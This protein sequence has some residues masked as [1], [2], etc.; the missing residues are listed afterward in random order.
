MIRHLSLIALLLAATPRWPSRAG[1]WSVPIPTRAAALQSAPAAAGAAARLLAAQRAG[2]LFRRH[3]QDL[4][5]P[6]GLYSARAC[7]TENK[8]KLSPRCVVDLAKL[9]PSSVPPCSRSPLVRQPVGADPR[10]AQARVVGYGKRFLFLSLQPAGGG[11]A[12]GVGIDSQR[13]FL[14]AAARGAGSAAALPVR[15]RCEIAAHSSQRR[16]RPVGERSHHQGGPARDNIW[17]GDA[18]GGIVLKLSPQGKLLMTLGV[19]GKRGEWDEAKGQRLLW[20]AAGCG[21]RRQWRRLHR[22]GSRQ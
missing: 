5:G 17:I 16:H 19:R 22:P 20:R 7:L 15:S 21:L 18:N 12:T 13:Q 11:G 3:R 1:S 8:A 2:G 4:P 6:L 10:T 14:G 9:P